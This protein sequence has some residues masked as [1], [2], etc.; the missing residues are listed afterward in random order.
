[1]FRFEESTLKKGGTRLVQSEVFGGY[2][3]WVMSEWFL[4]G[5]WLRGKYEGFNRDLKRG[6]ERGGRV[7]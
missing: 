1:M 5:W 7:E 4:G 6:V 3:A 2:L